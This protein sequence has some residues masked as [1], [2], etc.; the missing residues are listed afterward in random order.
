[1]FLILP[2]SLYVKFWSS[3]LSTD[4]QRW[5]ILDS[6]LPQGRKPRLLPEKQRHQNRLLSQS[7]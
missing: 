2:T 1:M 7:T 6:S 3:P 5:P 4:G